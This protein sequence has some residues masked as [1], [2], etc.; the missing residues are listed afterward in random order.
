MNA[1]GS[2]GPCN[3]ATSILAT[4]TTCFILAINHELGDDRSTLW[5][6]TQ[7]LIQPEKAAKQHIGCRLHISF[8]PLHDSPITQYAIPAI[9]KYVLAINPLSFSAGD[10]FLFG[11]CQ[12][13]GSLSLVLKYYIIVGLALNWHGTMDIVEILNAMDL[14]RGVEEVVDLRAL[15]YISTYD[16]HLMCPICHCPFIRP[17][18]LQ[19][20]HVFCQKCINDA[21]MSSD[22]GGG[23]GA[24]REFRC[25]SC[26]ARATDIS[27]NVPRLLIN[28]CDD[29]RVRC[30]YSDEGCAEVMARGHVQLHVEKY[31]DYKL[32]PCPSLMCHQKT[33]K[34]NLNPDKCMHTTVKC[35]TCE[36]DVMEQDLRVRISLTYKI[37]AAAASSNLANFHRSI[38]ILSALVYEQR[39]PI[40]VQWYSAAH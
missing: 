32:L 40:A 9:C 38:K 16:E 3:E 33:R 5:Y 35:E 19:C 26:R 31:C 18:R 17:L 24:A 20:D 25:P 10:Q 2:L 11:P 28:M 13:T 1:S 7:P 37:F 15:D 34:K 14:D 4:A 36:E 8:Q 22:S 6:A 39:V 29:V 30:P 12:L 27:A 23:S 21:I